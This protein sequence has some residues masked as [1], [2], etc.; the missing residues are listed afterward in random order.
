MSY[1]DK[2][3]AA[4]K[5]VPQLL[6]GDAKAAFQKLIS[7]PGFISQLVAVGVAFAALQAIPFVGQIID[8]A[9]VV[10]LGFSVAW[11]LVAFLA[12]TWIASDE[13]SLRSAA[14][15][16]K[17]L[18]ETV[19][20]AAITGI[21][22]TAARALKGIKV[23]GSPSTVTGVAE[24]LNT[25]NPRISLAYESLSEKIRGV[26]SAEQVETIAAQGKLLGL[27]NKEISDFLEMGSIAKPGKKPPKMPLTPEQLQEQMQNWVNVIKPRNYPYLFENKEAFNR[28][29]SEIQ[30]LLRKYGVPEG[31]IVVQG[32]SLRTPKAKDVDVAIFV[33]DQE[34]ATYVQK[35]KDGI[36]QR[37]SSE[38]ARKKLLKQIDKDAQRGFVRR[39]NFDRLGDEDSFEKELATLIGDSFSIDIDVSVM[40][41]SSE[42]A[43]EP[44]LKF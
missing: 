7:D 10:C 32:S 29:K 1:Q 34:F 16:L 39:Y 20:I 22:L 17:N 19:G 14:V 23:K 40:K 28:F 26:Y 21:L 4:A 3:V 41:S 18:V 31:D 13:E 24:G 44:Y 33:S 37:V 38:V 6:A 12:K 5:M 27:K 43:L 15:E 30:G 36:E 8:A 42:L 9:L 25:A 35:C 2:L 11:S